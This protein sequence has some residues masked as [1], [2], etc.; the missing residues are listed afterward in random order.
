MEEIEEEIETVMVET[1]SRGRLTQ[2]Q[3]KRDDLEEQVDV[4]EEEEIVQKVRKGLKPKRPQIG[5]DEVEM[6]EIEEFEIKEDKSMPSIALNVPSQHQQVVALD[7]TTEQAPGKPDLEKA[8][9]TLDTITP[10]TEQ[11]VP[12]QEKEIDNI[13]QIKPVARKASVSIS[14][15]EPYS[16]TETT[17]QASTGEF[18]DTFK[19]TSYEA[20]PGI[21]PSEGLVVSETLTHD[22]GLSSLTITKQ[23]ISRTADVSVTVQEATTVYETM[24]SQKEVPTED[25]VS[26]LTAKAEGSILPQIG[27]S[28]YE[29]Q[30]GLAEDKLEPMKTVSTKPRVNVTAVEPLVVEEVRAEDKPGKYYPEL[31]VPTEVATETIISQQQRVTEEMHAPEKEGEYI[32]GRLPPS[33]KAQIGISYGNETAIVQQN[34]VQESEGIFVSERKA[35]TFEATPN[36]SLLEGVSVST[37][38]TQDTE[39]A[40]TIEEAKKAVADFN[41]VEITSA[42]TVETV[43]SEKEKEYQPG[44]K[45]STKTAETSIYSLEIGSIASTIVQ[46]SEGIYQPDQIPTKVLAE[47]S[48]RPEEHVMVSEIQTADYPSDFNEELKYVQESGIVTVQL[49]EAKMVQETMTHD[50]EEKMEEI[51][52]PEERVVETSYDAIRG[53]EVFQT[54]SIE[55]EADLKIFEMPESHRGKTVPT[56]PVVSLEVEMTQPEDNLGEMKNEVPSAGVAKVEPIS[57][58]ETVVGETIIA[59]DVAPVRKDKAPESKMAE[60]TVDEIESVHTTMVIASEKESEYTE[61]SEVKGAYASTEFTTQV[62]PIFEEVRTHSPTGEYVPEDKPTSGVAQTSHV[63]LESVTVAMQ[64]AAEKEDLYKIDVKPDEKTAVV[65]LIEPRPGAT[66]LEIV[67]HD[68]ENVYSPDTKPQDYTAQPLVSGH[69]VA[70]KSE[71][72]VEQSA[73]D[74]SIDK[75]K[76]G[77]AIAQ[78][79]AMEELIVTETTIAET[80][81]T[82]DEEAL[83]TTQSAE[84]QIQSRTEKLTVTEVMSVQ[85]E[86]KLEVEDMPKER[87]VTLGITGGHEVAE[88][89]ETVL[90]SN[91]N[92]LEKERAKEEHASQEQSGLEVVEQTVISVSEKESPLQEDIKPDVKKIDVTFEE[93][94]GIV[95][96]MTYPEDKEG[97]FTGEEKPK[98][99]EA[100]VDIIT[101]GVASKFEILSDTGLR[102]LP[103]ET[104]Q[105]MKP[106]TTILPIEAAVSEEVQTRE[107]EAPLTEFKPADKKATLEFVTGEGLI[108]SAITTQDKESILPEV[109]KPEIKSATF[110]IPTHIVAQTSETTTTDYVGEYKR[111][112]AP[113][114]TATADHITFHSIIAS[115]TAPGDLEKPLE[116]F[117]QPDK[118]TVEVTFEEEIGVTVTETITSDKEKEYFKKLEMQ[119]EQAIPSFDAHKVAQMTEVTPVAVSADLTV[120]KPATFAATTEQVPFESIVQT[121]TIVSETEKEFKDKPMIGNKAEVSINEIISAMTSTEVAADKEDILQIP[122]KPSEKQASVQFAGHV[123]AEKIEVTVDSSA[124]RLEEVKPVSASAVPSSIPLEAVISSE[125]QPTEAEGLLSKEITPLQALADLSVVAEQS[126]QV[127]AVVLEDKEVEYKPEELPEVKTAGKSLVSGHVVAET[128][129]QVVDFSTAELVEKKPSGATA[130]PEHIPFTSLIETQTVVQESEETFVPGQRPEDKKAVVDL[131][132]SRKIVTVS[133]ITPADKESLYVTEEQP[134]KHAASVGLDT[135]HAIAETTTVSVEDSIDEVK[136]EKPDTKKAFASQEVY[137]SILVSQDMVQDQE[138]IFEGKFKPAVQ[139]VEISIEEGKKVTTVTEVRAADKEELLKAVQEEKT[140]AAVPAIVSGHEVAERTEIIP[141]SST[142]KVDIVKPTT[143]TAQIGQKPLETVEMIEQV[144]AEKEGDRIEEMPL[145][146]TSARVTIDEDRFIA[147]TE[148]ATTQDVEAELSDMKKPREEV[149]KPAMEGKEV[150]EQMEVNL[151][152]GLGEVPQVPKPTTFAVHPTQTTMEGVDIT[153]TVAQEHSAIFEEKMKVDER[154]AKVSFVEGKSVT[155]SHVITQDKEDTMKITKQ[156]ESTAE[157]ILTKV[158]MDVAQTAQVFVDQSTGSV[159]P[160]KTQEVKAHPKQDALEPIIVEETPSAEREG[161]FDKYPKTISSIAVPTFEEGHGISV[162]EVTSAE[163]ESLLTE[164]KLDVS[165]T[166]STTIIAERGILETTTIESQVDIAEKIDE[167]M[168]PQVAVPGQDTFESIIVNENIAEESERTFE[169]VFKPQIQ[170]ADVDIQKVTPLHITETITEDKESILDVAPKREEVK[171]TQDINL[172]ETVIGSI[173]ESMQ[174]IQEIHEQ[175]RVSSQ[176]TMSQTVIETAVKMETTVGEREDTFEG[177][178]LKPEQQKGKPQIEGLSTV[179]ITEVVSSEIEDVLP[180]AVAPKEQQAYPSLTGREAPEVMQVITAAT[181]ELFEKVTQLKEEQGKVEIEELS[182]VS[183]SEV[184]SNEAEDI[185]TCKSMPKDQR[186]DFN[187][188]GREVAETSQV[189]TVDKA[190]D[191]AV[192]RPEEQKGKPKLDELTPLT[193]SHVVSNEAE[194]IMPTAEIPKEKTAKPSLIGRDVA[195]TMQVLTVASAEELVAP[196]APEEQKGEPQVVELAPLTVSQVISQEAEEQLPTPEMPVEREAQPNLMGRDVAQKLE[197]LTMANIDILAEIIKPGEQKGVPVLEE[198]VSLSVSQT[199]STEMENVLPAPEAPVEKMVEP[200]LT[201]RD[202]A[203]T[204][205]I[206]TLISAAELTSTRAPEEQKGQP[207][208]EELSSITVS[209]PVSHETEETLESPVVPSKVTAKP[210][211]SGREVAETSQVL[212]VTNVE[213]LEKSV[214]P[215]EQ[216]GTPRLDELKSLTV[217]QVVSSELE[218]KLPSPEK[219]SEKVAQTKLTGREVAEK[220]EVRTVTHVEELQKLEKPEGQKGKPDVEELSF[221]TVS[222]VVS[223][224]AEKELP[225]PEAPQKYKAHPQMSSTEVAETLEVITMVSTEELPKSIAPEEQKGKRQLDELLSLSVSEVA[226]G[227]VEMGLP[228]PD[229]PTAQTAIPS[230]LGIHVAQQSQV[231]P[232]AATEEMQEASKPETK[233]IMPEQIPF[234]SIE[235]SQTVSQES[236]GT[237]IVEKTAKKA[238]ADVSFRVSESIEVIQVTATEQESKEMIKGIA[239]EVSALPEVIKH[240]VALKTEVQPGDVAAEFEVT[241]PESKT[242]RG[243]DEIQQGVIVTEHLTGSELE[244]ELP[245]SVIPF[246][247]LASVSI[248]TGHLDHIVGEYYCYQG[249]RL[250]STGRTSMRTIRNGQEDDLTIVV[251]LFLERLIGSIDAEER[252]TREMFNCGEAG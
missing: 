34:V 154:S 60:V 247:K 70:L 46:E 177:K 45:P 76:S 81:K 9:L 53:V 4:E 112:E 114:A 243:V 192:K 135:T 162:T 179:T 188:L 127:S 72:L 197:V 216:K 1:D 195:E 102:D 182:S 150:A 80:E 78:R 145:Q 41:V 37:V 62:A 164:K 2:K 49:T 232:S 103:H 151:R 252:S 58:Q 176:A 5:R 8:K 97:I 61:I 27:L 98:G 33:Q 44:D 68:R 205:Q 92:I 110:D 219:P 55:K 233:Q 29:V 59:E 35:D 244:S 225:T 207:N 21:I 142:G 242:A 123:I 10:L 38:Q 171:A 28:V 117:V 89:Q 85:E 148:A 48:I 13:S 25:F 26:P 124:G 201:G 220:T 75:P 133:Q 69:T 169:G 107:T 167:V 137:Q 217:S 87:K 214:L 40:L 141:H 237:F 191:L 203:E 173:V 190:E 165:Q 185:L 228:T 115:E 132:E 208:V 210:A 147:I 86:E 42:V 211:L 249:I 126:I 130:V 57:L 128:T 202:V 224:E 94:E 120:S 6:E 12:V 156:E 14:P 51:V 79:D 174:S 234:E 36:V 178:E 200:S 88:M 215:E 82:R 170:K 184:I 129:M 105:E 73:A 43:P 240:E 66:V 218:H 50:R 77:K 198:F 18:A 187:I 161:T 246:A 172:H 159:Q 52:K 160:F 144:L 175:K 138:N 196:K 116:D 24:V 194:E 23:E 67:P 96:G 22:A 16:I 223:T 238:T 122:E 230:L 118:K 15:V 236:E 212:T 241:K 140:R 213:D 181:A 121:E 199:I 113:T 209:Q 131:E 239:K 90:A 146:K 17:V 251:N 64:E 19:P 206:L 74:M 54:T 248:E 222:E 119:G 125:T 93:G 186:A 63:P 95:V 235:Q 134:S 11:L 84:V 3:K 7:R 183:I 152:E 229:E 100:T 166:A 180:A 149:A 143:A 83:P 245:E 221:I 109:E 47:T 30:E 139:K 193:V 158:G 204:M 101:Q 157:V 136:I 231:I 71:T 20:T 108:V 99:V 153:E 250:P 111:E 226:F 227:E 168:K 56:H 32:P 155:V 189:T 91:F 163:V 106:K 39:A 31:I 65:E 104:I